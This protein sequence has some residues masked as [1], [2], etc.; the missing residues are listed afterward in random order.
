ML[1]ISFEDNG[2]GVD[3]RFAKKIF[4]VFQ[5]LHRDESVY[6]GTGIGLALAK[7]I[8]ESHNGSLSLDTTFA[9][10]ARFVLLLPDMT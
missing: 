5:R 4:D 8:A 7:R 9:Q 6:Q 1:R 10:G 3:P 2:I